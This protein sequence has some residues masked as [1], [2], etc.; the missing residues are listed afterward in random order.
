MH[1]VQALVSLGIGGSEM[2]AVETTEFLR[3]AGHRVTVVAAN[4][5]LLDR[6]NAA[7][8]EFLDW[9]IGRKRLGTLR[10]I[11]QLRSW[12]LEHQPD[13]VHVHSRLPAW[14]C[15]LALRKLPADKRP[16]FI[17]SMHGQYSVSSYSAIMARGDLV[18]AVS[19]HIREYTL[20]NY[21]PRH[22][23]QLHT[24]YGGTSRYDFPY[25]YQPSTEW[26]Q[27]TF[28]EF[29]QLEG[30]RILLLPG[31][32]SRYKGHAT[33]IELLAILCK[34]N[35]MIFMPSYSAGQNR[36]HG[37]SMSL[38]AL[39]NVTRSATT[40]IL[41]GKNRYAGLDDGS[42]MVFNLC[43]D[44]PEAFG[45]IAPE[46]LSL[47]VPVIAWDHGVFPGDI[48]QMFP[49]GAVDPDNLPALVQKTREFL[50]QTPMVKNSDAFS[51]KDSMDQ[52]MRLYDSA[53]EEGRSM[54]LLLKRLQAD[55]PCWLAVSFFA[56]L[57][58][59]R[60][61]EIPL[62]AFAL[63]LPFL[64]RSADHRQRIRQVGCHCRP[65]LSLFLAAHGGVQY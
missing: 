43:S 23:P 50:Q 15:Y 53:C 48:K 42:S 37:I 63:C 49:A 33:F 24:I 31:R 65:H 62:S 13:I 26:L 11:R 54:N 34:Q 6:V 18:I 8:A 28:A 41:R 1:V 57:P 35:L 40:D 3:A 2:V 12:L 56:L 19:N 39:P 25:G 51:L 9:P 14:I 27:R 59:G 7:G 46:A 30:K 52:T 17:T 22:S 58:F 5:P 20:K 44:P 38:K 4:G 45:R 21:L 64:A 55:W 32:L 61:A 10:Y 47:G 60:L 36:A 16:V 29:P